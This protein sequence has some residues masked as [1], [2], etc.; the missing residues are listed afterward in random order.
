MGRFSLSALQ[1]LELTHGTWAD[2]F[3]ALGADGAEF[4]L[5]HVPS[6]TRQTGMLLN[7]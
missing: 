3:P 5:E 7:S 4:E 2:G 6:L 1:G